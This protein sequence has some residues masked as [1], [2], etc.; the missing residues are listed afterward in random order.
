MSSSPAIEF[1]QWRARLPLISSGAIVLILA[2]AMLAARA[3][4]NRRTPPQSDWRAPQRTQALDRMAQQ[5]TEL[6]LEIE[7]APTRDSPADRARWETWIQNDYRPRVSEFR[8]RL[9][10]EPLGGDAYSALLRAADR[11][12]AFAANPRDIRT[13][14]SARETADSA[15]ALIREERARVTGG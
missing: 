3:T 10:S 2:A 6:I 9:L 14:E 15:K 12:G 13:L 11:L 8:L 4:L 1:R 5:L 7:L